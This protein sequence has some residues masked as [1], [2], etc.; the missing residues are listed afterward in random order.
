MKVDKEQRVSNLERL[1]QLSDNYSD[2]ITVFC[3]HDVEAF[4]RLS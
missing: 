4:K 3:A 1:K 2:E